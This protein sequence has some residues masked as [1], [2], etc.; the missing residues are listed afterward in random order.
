MGRD[1]AVLVLDE[2][3][4]VEIGGQMDVSGL[5]SLLE[6]QLHALQAFGN[7]AV[8]VLQTATT[9]AFIPRLQLLLATQ[10]HVPALTAR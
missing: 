2:A 3:H 7:R 6:Q 8:I 5:G 1:C 10:F 9:A 4:M